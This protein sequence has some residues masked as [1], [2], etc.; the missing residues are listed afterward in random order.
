MPLE[1]VFA[2]RWVAREHI[3]DNTCQPCID[4]DGKLYKNREDA[5]ADY[6]D[7]KGYINCVG[8]EYGNDC[9][10]IVVKRRGGRAMTPEQIAAINNARLISGKFSARAFAVT[11]GPTEGLRMVAASPATGN[12][13]MYIYDY[14]GGYDGVNAIDIVQALDGMSG[15]VDLH[16][17]SGG[18]AIFEGAAIY[19][20]LDNYAGGTIHGFVDGV[21]ASAA[22]VIAMAC[23][24]ITMEPAATM[25]VH[26]G[27]GG[28][29]G[30]A[31]D[32]RSLADVLDM[33]TETMAG[34]YAMRTGGTTAAW[35]DLLNSGD[36]WYNADAAIE[37]KL[38][39]RKGGKKKA[40]PDPD[41]MPMDPED[42]AHLDL[43]SV[44]A[45]AFTEKIEPKILVPVQQSIEP[46][47]VG[48]QGPEL[49]TP[50]DLENLRTALKGIKA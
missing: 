18:G 3:D 20:T 35:L 17:N 44:I 14:I 40:L 26:A 6:P 7:G 23:E 22:S 42:K 46:I 5:Y 28:V 15:D 45:A 48:E 12:A 47:F 34:I 39:T 11:E 24:T 4:N 16:I 43:L 30:T 33:L 32:M 21:A 31:K 9:R 8:A 27:S 37:A 38:A 50:E 49:L 10:G 1:P 2:N 29:W 36:T 13:Q 25:M 41:E 19:S